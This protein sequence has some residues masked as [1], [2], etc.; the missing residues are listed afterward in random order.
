MGAEYER[1]GNELISALRK[2]LAEQSDDTAIRRAADPARELIQRLLAR[3]AER[4]GRVETRSYAAL[5]SVVR[6]LGA[7]YRQRGP[8]AVVDDALRVDILSRLDEAEAL[9]A[10]HL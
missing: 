6:D 1:T 10:E 2:S 9:I 8:R 3:G 4:D 7:F 5:T